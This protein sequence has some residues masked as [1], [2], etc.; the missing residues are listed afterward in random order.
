MGKAYGPEHAYGILAKPSI[1]LSNNPN[2]PIVYVL[3]PITVVDQLISNG[4]IKDGVDRKIPSFCIL[5][6]AS[7]NV[8]TGGKF[9]AD[10][11]WLGL[12]AKRSYFK[13]LVVTFDKN[14][15]KSAAD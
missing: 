8:V 6:G 14:Q 3:H 1:G 2:D 11:F 4:I 9:E 15:T 13:L 5:F 10:F 7:K 12:A